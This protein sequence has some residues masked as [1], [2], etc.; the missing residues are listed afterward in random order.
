MPL[1]TKNLIVGVQKTATATAPTVTEQVTKE[2]F[3]PRFQFGN[4]INKSLPTP[5]EPEKPKPVE[6]KIEKKV[7]QVPET[8]DNPKYLKKEDGELVRHINRKS[9]Y[10]KD[11]LDLDS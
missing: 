7:V 1:I 11:V 5:T 9:Q 3:G 10:L 2:E 8:R 6:K 4:F